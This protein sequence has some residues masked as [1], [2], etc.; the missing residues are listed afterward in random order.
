M[1]FGRTEPFDEA[2]LSALYPGGKAAYLEQ[3][4]VAL[5]ATIAAGFILGEDRAEILA[6]A[7][8]SS[9]PLVVLEA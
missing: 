4:E 2:T 9:Y 6:V 1:L 7:A 3:F 8:S 5:D